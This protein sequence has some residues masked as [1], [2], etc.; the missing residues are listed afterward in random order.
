VDASVKDGQGA[1][2]A[3]ATRVLPPSGLPEHCLRRHSTTLVTA[4]KNVCS[5]SAELWA[6]TDLLQHVLLQPDTGARNLAILLDCQSVIKRLMS[7]DPGPPP[8]C[9][10]LADL[11]ALAH[12]GWLV[13]MWF[14]HSHDK[15]EEQTDQ[16]NQ[17]Q[18]ALR[19]D[20]EP[21]TTILLL[22]EVYKLAA[23]ARCAPIPRRT[24]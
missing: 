8:E 5:Y 7:S 23:L 24:W 1:A 10:A 12:R 19:T 14:F 2:Y 20:D 11:R 3:L 22:A 16:P 13:S 15:L 21:D 17:Q 6:L 9:T 18:A 4:G